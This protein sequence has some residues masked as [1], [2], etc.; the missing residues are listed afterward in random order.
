MMED[1]ESKICGLTKKTRKIGVGDLST[2]YIYRRRNSVTCHSSTTPASDSHR[3]G[4]HYRVRSASE[5]PVKAGV[6]EQCYRP[7]CF[8]HSAPGAFVGEIVC[9]L[10]E[11]AE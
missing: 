6:Y 11:K 3:P 9:F 7:F 1:V 10:R 2:L 8:F 4:A 5:V